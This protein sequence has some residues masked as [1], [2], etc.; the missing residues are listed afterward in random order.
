MNDDSVTGAR[1]ITLSTDFDN[2][3]VHAVRSERG[4]SILR[5]NSLDFGQYLGI[6]FLIVI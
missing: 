2:F 6:A 4:N 5:Q 1:V 3:N